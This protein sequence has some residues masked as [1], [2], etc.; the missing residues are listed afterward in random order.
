M[1]PWNCDVFVLFPQVSKHDVSDAIPWGHM[2]VV[3]S[4][5]V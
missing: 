1:T 2:G 4:K 5:S 3:Q